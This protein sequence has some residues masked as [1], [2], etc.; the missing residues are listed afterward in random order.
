MRGGK[1]FFPLC[2]TIATFLQ[3]FG[4]LRSDKNNLTY[5]YFTPKFIFNLFLK[6]RRGGGEGEFS[7]QQGNLR[8]KAGLIDVIYCSGFVITLFGS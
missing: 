5:S 1:C 3:P 2:L 8:G 6:L 7:A 4:G